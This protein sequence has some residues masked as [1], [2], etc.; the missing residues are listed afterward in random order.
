VKSY[1]YIFLVAIYNCLN[2]VFIISFIIFGV[3]SFK[4]AILIFYLKYSC[5]QQLNLFTWVSED[6]VFKIIKRLL[7]VKI[8]SGSEFSFL[9]VF[10]CVRA[11]YTREVCKLPLV[12]LP[13][14]ISSHQVLYYAKDHS[15]V[16]IYLFI[17]ISFLYQ[18][19]SWSFVVLC[20]HFYFI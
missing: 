11:C 1:I 14:C 19:Y 4:I 17:W 12:T 5:L 18:I 3:V 9:C 8:L 16:F 15:F 7:V 2:D 20:L 6:D 10:M 13:L